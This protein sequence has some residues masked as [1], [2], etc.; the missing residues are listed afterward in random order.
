MYTSYFGLTEKPFNV[1][2]DPRFFYT[3]PLYQE[4][5][6]TLLHGIRERKGFVVLTG[7]VGTGKT[8]LLRRLMNN[9]E[10]TVRFVFIYNTTLTFE[11]L[12]SY[13]CDELGLDV[14]DDG[15]LRKIQ[16]LNEFLIEQLRK[17]GTGVLLIDEAQNLGE[18]VL[19]SLRLLSNLETRSEKLLQIVLVGQPELESKLD[20]PQLRQVK[21]R[22]V[23]RCRLDR[24]KDREV[25]PFISYRLRAAG[26]NGRTLFTPDAIDQIAYYSR[27]IPRVI[28]IIADNALM[29]AYATSQKK[30]SADIIREVGD[31]LRLEPEVQDTEVHAPTAGTESKNGKDEGPQPLAHETLQRKSMR[32]ARVGA[33]TPSRELLAELKPISQEKERTFQEIPTERMVFRIAD[34]GEGRNKPITIPREGLRVFSKI[35]GFRD[36]HT[37]AK[38]LRLACAYTANVIDSLHR[39]GL[40]EVVPSLTKATP[41]AVSPRFFDITTSALTEAMGPMAPVVVRDQI[42]TLGESPEAFP[43]TRIKELVELVSREVLNEILKIRFQQRMSEEIHSL[44]MLSPILVRR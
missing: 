30:V 2:P 15:R 26:Y 7:E 5:Y 9:L 8:T 29:I 38:S 21:Q 33:G 37:I 32:L 40:V 31:D 16:A 4:A 28:N 39:S 24:L 44:N 13:A 14:K 3:N 22:V 23:V 18:E 17:G 25:G 20:Q 19:E 27:G 41:E 12:L 11:E 35:D 34:P 10:A 42:T 43:K 36:V 1:T 6:A